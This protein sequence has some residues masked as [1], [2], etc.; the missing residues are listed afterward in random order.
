MR[1]QRP[2]AHSPSVASNTVS[3]AWDTLWIGCALA[4]M[5]GDDPYGLIRDG[6]IATE[7][8]RIAW[9]GSRSD[10]PD[11]PENCA[12]EIVDL[13]G[14]LITP[15][16]ID[17]HTHLVYAGNRAVEFE[18]RLA[19]M[20]Y[21]EI[22]QRGGGIHNTVGLTRG[23]SFDKLLEQAA[24]RI[25]KMRACGVTTIEIKSGYGLD[26]ETELRMLRVARALGERFPIDVRT[27]Y[28]G[29]HVVPPEF[30]SRRDEYVALVCDVLRE[31]AREGLIDAVDAFCEGIAFSAAE[32]R[33]IFREAQELGIPMKL[34]AGQLSYG[35]GAA[36]AAEFHAL[37]V[38]H[39]E[40][41]SET[42]V[43]LLAKSGVVVVLLPTAAYF[44]GETQLPPVRLL[45]R[46]G[47][48]M[49]IATDCNPG[50]S[51]NPSLLVALNM[52]CVRF[53]LLSAAAMRGVTAHAAQALGIRERVGTLEKGKQADFALW[54]AE[55]PAELPYGFGQTTCLGTVKRGRFFAGTTS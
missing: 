48:P 45:A 38:D 30:A 47:V 6:A 22:A 16:L 31:G 43:E 1:S 53:G 36:L 25:E 18:M 19:G 54:H 51:P 37:S 5:S 46:A 44:T 52:A 20:T 33:R 26:R 29:A 24:R 50:T 8:E 11:I 2:C 3:P 32:I 28:L 21:A 23:A 40:R 17:C 12:R 13:G 14:K 9:V 42:D 34:H 4:T 49:A 10:L 39:C 7:G 35:D 55:H 27:T 41:L 15:G